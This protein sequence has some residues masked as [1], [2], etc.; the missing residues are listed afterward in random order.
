MKR[1]DQ[2]LAKMVP[3][4]QVRSPAGSP[5]KE[6]SNV[7]SKV[8]SSTSSSQIVPTN[9]RLYQQWRNLDRQELSHEPKY[10]EPKY[11]EPKHHKPKDHDGYEI[12][13]L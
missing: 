10:H 5:G 2:I 7:G 9:F 4:K 8:S 1:V 13:I 12:P 11:H 6:R 3:D